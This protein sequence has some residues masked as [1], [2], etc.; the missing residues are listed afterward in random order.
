[1]KD[2]LFNFGLDGDPSQIFKLI[3]THYYFSPDISRQEF[4]KTFL[5]LFTGKIVTD[6]QLLGVKL[7]ILGHNLPG[8]LLS[9]YD[10][11]EIVENHILN[12]THIGNK[13]LTEIGLYPQAFVDSILLSGYINIGTIRLDSR[14]RKFKNFNLKGYT[15]MK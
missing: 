4:M 7:T 1:M 2:V 5:E 3:L 14:Y 12:V 15:Y 9:F 13:V 6:E 8:K 10:D 11:S